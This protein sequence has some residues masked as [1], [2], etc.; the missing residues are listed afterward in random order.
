MDT[1]FVDALEKRA[2]TLLPPATMMKIECAGDTTGD[3][4]LI[5]LL[6]EVQ[7][8]GLRGEL[9]CGEPCETIVFEDRVLLRCHGCARMD[10]LPRVAGVGLGAD[11][12][13]A[14][15]RALYALTIPL[16][17]P[18][19]SLSGCLA[20]HVWGEGPV[21]EVQ[22]ACILNRVAYLRYPE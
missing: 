1:S 15:R 19:I 22:Y 5:S 17:E 3:P 9:L 8:R 2:R 14:R 16:D 10:V 6:E 4:A 11:R 20:A 21:R 13:E 7:G 12:E 18:G